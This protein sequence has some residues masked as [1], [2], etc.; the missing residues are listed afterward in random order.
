[1]GHHALAYA[2]ERCSCI[3]GSIAAGCGSW[4]KTASER[5][6]DSIDTMRLH[7]EELREGRL[8]RLVSSLRELSPASMLRLVRA[9]RQHD[10]IKVKRLWLQVCVLYILAKAR[11]PQLLLHVK[12][13]HNYLCGR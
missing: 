3:Q 12:G 11:C 13:G 7:W 8:H 6:H 9:M 2:I 1:M 10:R 4:G 5:L